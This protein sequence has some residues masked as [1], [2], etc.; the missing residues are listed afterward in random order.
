MRWVLFF[1]GLVNV[2]IGIFFLF[3]VDKG[4]QSIELTLTSVR[5]IIDF[6]ATYGGMILGLGIFFFVGV[7]RPEF[8]KAGLLCGVLLFSGLFLSRLAGLLINGSDTLMWQLLTVE[9][10]FIVLNGFFLKQSNG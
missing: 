4:A 6:R 7:W 1:D 9:A 3:W 5:S 8:A 2:S 10:L